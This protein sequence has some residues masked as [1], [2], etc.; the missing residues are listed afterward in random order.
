[1]AAWLLLALAA[2]RSA[3]ERRA[4]GDQRAEYEYAGGGGSS[5]SWRRSRGHRALGSHGANVAA[6]TGANAGRCSRP[7]SADPQR[8]LLASA[9]LVLSTKAEIFGSAGT[10]KSV[11]ADPA[12]AAGEL[13]SILKGG[14]DPV[15]GIFGSHQFHHTATTT[16]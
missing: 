2:A 15:I 16:C 6:R 9:P 3:G 1:L 8:F 5:P 10:G 4:R 7:A 14:Y 11:P 13:A 12:Q